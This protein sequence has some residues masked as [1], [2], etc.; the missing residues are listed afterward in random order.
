MSV[1]TLQPVETLARLTRVHGPRRSGRLH[2]NPDIK[3]SVD[4]RARWAARAQGLGEVW[5]RLPKKTHFFLLRFFFQQRVSR[6]ISCGVSCVLNSIPFGFCCSCRGIFR[7]AI[8]GGFRIH[9]SFRDLFRCCC[10][11]LAIPD[12]PGVADVWRLHWEAELIKL[13]ENMEVSAAMVNPLSLLFSPPPRCVRCIS[14]HGCGR[15]ATAD[16]QTYTTHTQA[17]EQDAQR[18]SR[19]RASLLSPP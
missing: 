10:F 15:V 2:A 17:A 3:K 8:D 6:L 16:R 14:A 11:Q 18:V 7:R 4:E 9:R 13:N 19:I 12:S 1:R 5:C